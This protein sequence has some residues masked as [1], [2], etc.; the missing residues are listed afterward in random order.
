MTGTDMV[1][2]TATAVGTCIML[3]QVIKSLRTKHVQDLSALM[4]TLYLANCALWFSYGIML[5]AKP[6]IV[7][8]AAG[9]AIG[10]I[11]VLLKAR[12]RRRGGVS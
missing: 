8:N 2:Y 9:F 3:P 12:Y 10:V 1:G 7:A 11:Q 6:V 5:P 4:L